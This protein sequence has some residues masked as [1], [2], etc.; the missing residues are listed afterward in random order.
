M[1]KNIISNAMKFTDKGEVTVNIGR[2]GDGL[3]SFTVTD[4]GIGIAEH[5]QQ[6]IFEAFR[7]ADGTTN[8]KYGGTG[9]GLSISR[10]LTRRL[11]GEISLTSEV[12]SRKHVHGHR[13]PKSMSLFQANR[14]AAFDGGDAGGNRQIRSN[15]Q[16]VGREKKRTAW[17]ISA[18]SQ[19][20]NH[21][22][23]TN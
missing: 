20:P 14:S 10:E 21:T 9:L 2:A 13:S 15:C 8:R 17:H 11:G 5:Q 12:G 18:S 19:V 7:Q 4:T 3:I 16:P 6:V 23:P 1:L 22:R